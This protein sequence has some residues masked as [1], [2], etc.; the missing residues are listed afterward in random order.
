MCQPGSLPVAWRDGRSD[1]WGWHDHEGSPH[2]PYSARTV[3]GIAW[4]TASSEEDGSYEGQPYE[5]GFDLPASV[6]RSLDA[7]MGSLHDSCHGETR[8]GDLLKRDRDA[9]ALARAEP[10]SACSCDSSV[11]S[12]STGTA[13][14]G[15]CCSVEGLAD[16]LCDFRMAMSCAQ[17]DVPNSPIS[18][19]SS[20]KRL[21]PIAPPASEASSRGQHPPPPPPTPLGTP[22]RLERCCQPA[23]WGGQDE[24][25]RAGGEEVNHGEEV[26]HLSQETEALGLMLTRPHQRPLGP[27][28]LMRKR[29][30]VSTMWGVLSPSSHSWASSSES[31]TLLGELC[32]DE[33]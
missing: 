21:R 33:L 9:S 8:V 27:L 11:A 15:A 14:L 12:L 2:S 22:G 18:I 10:A 26:R 5:T 25:E 24:R 16:S 23:D 31:G 7:S 4:E 1:A 30:K 13:S 17:P 32:G 6:R 3:A 28:P 20:A 19:E 29:R